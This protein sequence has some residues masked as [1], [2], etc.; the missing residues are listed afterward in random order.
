MGYELEDNIF[1]EVQSHDLKIRNELSKITVAVQIITAAENER[2]NVWKKASDFDKFCW[3]MGITIGRGSSTLNKLRTIR[4]NVDNSRRQIEHSTEIVRDA[5]AEIVSIIDSLV[6]PY[7]EPKDREYFESFAASYQEFLAKFEA[8]MEQVPAV[9]CKTDIAAQYE[10]RRSIP[11][12]KKDFQAF[13]KRG[14]ETARHQ[15]ERADDEAAAGRERVKTAIRLGNKKYCEEVNAI[16]V[17]AA[18]Q[19]LGEINYSW[20]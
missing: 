5:V 1:D 6:S 19:D 15:R 8:L 14:Q 4:D 7:M 2:P 13:V 10:I 18:T 16:A 11:S 17:R 9:P 12:N 3:Y 20:R